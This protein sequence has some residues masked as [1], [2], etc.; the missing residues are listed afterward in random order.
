LW[1]AGT[2]RPQ[3]FQAPDSQQ[4]HWLR[5]LELARRIPMWELSRERDWRNIEV[6]PELASSVAT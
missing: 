3:L 6:L 2:Y 5:C 4:R 1:Q